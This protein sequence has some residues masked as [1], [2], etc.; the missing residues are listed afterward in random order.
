MG[1]LSL[2]RYHVWRRFKGL[3][4]SDTKS[5]LYVH[6]GNRTDSKVAEDWEIKF[7]HLPNEPADWLQ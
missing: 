6:K 3:D 2:L 5:L 4:L 1:Y 7:Y